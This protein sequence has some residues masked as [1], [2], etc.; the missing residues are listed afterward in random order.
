MA[1]VQ[2]DTVPPQRQG[3]ERELPRGR[4]P[5]PEV[6]DPG[7]R[8]DI[9]PTVIEKAATCAARGV[10][11]VTTPR[12]RASRVRV[13]GRAVLLRLR[14]GVRYPEPVRETAARVRERVRDRVEHLTGSRVHHIDIEIVEMVR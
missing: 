6:H 14:I 2:T 8:V 12:H 4:H 9:V 7:G 5:L 10:A 1:H 13:S 3:D 11:G